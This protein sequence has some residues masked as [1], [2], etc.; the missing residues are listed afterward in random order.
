MNSGISQDI[1]AH[2]PPTLLTDTFLGSDGVT[3]KKNQY[4]SHALVKQTRVLYTS[5]SHVQP[6]FNCHSETNSLPISPTEIPNATH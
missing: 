4:T 2:V 6:K 1:T 5:F 3:G